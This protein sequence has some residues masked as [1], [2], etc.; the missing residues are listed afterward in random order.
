MRRYGDLGFPAFQHGLDFRERPLRIEVANDRQ[1]GMTATDLLLVDRLDLLEGNSIDAR[2]IL[3]QRWH[4]TN[5]VLRVR[6]QGA[7]EFQAGEHGRFSRPAGRHEFHAPL[8]L[9]ELRNR[10]RWLAKD[11]RQEIE[12]LWQRLL[13]GTDREGE[14]AESAAAT[15]PTASSPATAETSEPRGNANAER[16]HGFAHGLPIVL[17][18]AGH[19]HAREACRPR[20]SDP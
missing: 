16:L 8:G 12:S 5:I 3:L 15:A 10:E 20:S 19:H 7:T 4:V 14:L 1:L 17:L 6:R 13:L 11:F 2:D 18:G 9:L